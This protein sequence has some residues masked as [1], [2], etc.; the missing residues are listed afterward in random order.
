MMNEY[1]CKYKNKNIMLHVQVLDYKGNKALVEPTNIYHR[2]IYGAF[3]VS[4]DKLQK[5]YQ[6]PNEYDN[7]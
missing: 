1:F 7:R 2:K 5:E 3:W 4:K 6:N